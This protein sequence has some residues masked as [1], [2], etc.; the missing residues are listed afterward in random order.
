MAVYRAEFR[1]GGNFGSVL[2]LVFVSICIDNNDLGDLYY[3]IYSVVIVEGCSKLE[4]VVPGGYNHG[5]ERVS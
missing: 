2:V 4:G 5:R 1:F 3:D